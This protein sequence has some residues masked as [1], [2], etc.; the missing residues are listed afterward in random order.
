[1]EIVLLRGTL[2]R[3]NALAIIKLQIKISTSS[4]FNNRCHQQQIWIL[5]TN[6][7]PTSN[8]FD[9]MILVAIIIMANHWL[10]QQQVIKIFHW[11]LNHRMITFLISHHLSINAVRVIITTIISLLSISTSNHFSYY[12]YT[13]IDVTQL[14][15]YL[16][17]FYYYCVSFI[18][19][20]YTK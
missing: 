6:I 17:N 8:H 19:Y 3:I 1:M 2:H 20:T 16:Y 11:K 5:S 15:P 10:L 4:S 9:I 7:Q 13:N 18:Q 12:N 14:Q